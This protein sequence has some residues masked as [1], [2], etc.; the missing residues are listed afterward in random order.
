MVLGNVQEQLKDPRL[1][2]IANTR[3]MHAVQHDEQLD[4]QGSQ[5]GSLLSL[6]EQRRKESWND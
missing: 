4:E 6:R 1:R 3:E 2:A 5:A